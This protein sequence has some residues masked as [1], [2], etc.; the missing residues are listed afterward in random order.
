MISKQPLHAAQALLR[1]AKKL[2]D[3]TIANQLMILAAGSERCA[4]KSDLG[5]AVRV[6]APRTDRA[7]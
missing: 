4:R 3:E 1:I 6:D 7:A 2:T 5:T